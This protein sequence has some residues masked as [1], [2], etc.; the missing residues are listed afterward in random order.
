MNGQTKV[1]GTIL[2]VI[3][4]ALSTLLFFVRQEQRNMQREHAAASTHSMLFVEWQVST[5]QGM[6]TFRPQDLDCGSMA[7]FYVMSYDDQRKAI[8]NALCEATLK[9]SV[10][11]LRWECR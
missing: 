11:P 3:I 8:A 6:A 4:L 9:G 7:A 2:V 1:V 5:R 10:V